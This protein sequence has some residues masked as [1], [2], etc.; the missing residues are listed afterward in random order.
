[1]G[2]RLLIL[3][4]L[5]VLNIV[6][7]SHR[8][9]LQAWAAGSHDGVRAL[10]A[11]AAPD[12]PADSRALDGA[13]ASLRALRGRVLVLHF[14]TF[15]CSNCRH[16]LPRY[17]DWAARFGARGL[18]V[19]GV[20]TPEMDYERD[21]AALRRFVRDEH[22]SWPVVVDPDETIWRRYGV[23]AWPTIILIDRSG[24]VRAT[25]VGDD[26]SAAIET[27]IEQLLGPPTRR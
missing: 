19:L 8:S 10:E 5:V 25:F 1:M 21:L 6:V 22:I 2:K 20:H 11:A 12:L 4:V 7:F 27:A 14:W 23:A 13:P 15:G 24:V 9:D 18:A 26:K 3:G 17:N 16:M